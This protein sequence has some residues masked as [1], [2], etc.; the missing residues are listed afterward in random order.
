MI[1][2]ARFR[3]PEKQRVANRDARVLVGDVGEFV[4]RGD[5]ANRVDVRIGGLQIVVDL[6]ARCA[7]ILDACRF[8]VEAFDDRRAAGADQNFIGRDFL[9]AGSVR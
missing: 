3:A 6:H 8:E 1:E 4:G 2:R 7:I 5:I 9:V